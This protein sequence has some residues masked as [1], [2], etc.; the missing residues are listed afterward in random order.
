MVLKSFFMLLIQINLSSSLRFLRFCFRYVSKLDS[1]SH[2]KISRVLSIDDYL[3]QTKY[4]I[5]LSIFNTSLQI[6][7]LISK[8][9]V[10]RHAMYSS[11]LNYYDR[12]PILHSLSVCFNLFG[13]LN[14][15]RIEHVGL[16]LRKR[17]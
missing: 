12:P 8:Q 4:N 3:K 6:H 16:T 1:K 11:V 7:L 15:A 2:P 10:I 5:L 9:L 14:P 17:N 13:S